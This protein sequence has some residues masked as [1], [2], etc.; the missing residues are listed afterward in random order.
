MNKKLLIIYL[1]LSL[2]LSQTETEVKINLF[3]KKALFLNLTNLKNGLY[4]QN[5]TDSNVSF[6]HV[7]NTKRGNSL[8]LQWFLNENEIV[9]QNFSFYVKKKYGVFKIGQFP[10][11]KIYMQ[12]N[13]SS[14]SMVISENAKYIPAISFNTNWLKINN[15]LD[16]KFELY[17]GK[18]LS[19]KNYSEGPYL[20]YKS[21]LFRKKINHSV[22]GFSVQHAVQFGGVNQYGEKIPLNPRL[23]FRMIAAQNGDESQPK[24]DQNYKIGNG[25]GSYT[26]FVSNDLYNGNLN[27]YYEH[28]FDDKSG[29]KMKNLQDGLFGLEYSNDV[30]EIL[31]ENLNTRNQSGNQHPPGVDSYYWH[32]TY[33]F[34]WTNKGLSIGNSLINPES[35]RK[36]V[37]TLTSKVK[38]SSIEIITQI[39]NIKEYIPY[40]DKN[41]N[42]PYENELDILANNNNYI[43]GINK[44]RA[45]GHTVSLFFARYNSNSN[46]Q[47]SYK[48]SF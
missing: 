45:N 38:F 12:N 24:I 31:F 46:I 25:L 35:N 2:A 17:Q 48:L 20:H 33:E 13:Y 44:E 7:H 26:F 6:K 41:N 5:V 36:L 3:Q 21:V 27:T 15:L 16:I 47:L 28:F 23:F 19:Q 1:L 4:N 43:L 34:G 29:T 11:E 22:I 30:F 32:Q 14:G 9:L 10:I 42:E 18:F 8:N 40:K 37:N 39:S